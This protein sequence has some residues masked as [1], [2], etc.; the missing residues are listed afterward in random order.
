MI[1]EK[2]TLRKRAE[3]DRTTEQALLAMIW[4]NELDPQEFNESSEVLDVLADIR[5][6]QVNVTEG[7]NAIQEIREGEKH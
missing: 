7:W 3:K 6:H 5:S 1:Q 2:P 4:R